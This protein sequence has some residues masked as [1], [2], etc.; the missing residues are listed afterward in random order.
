MFLSF[1]LG[2][3]IAD[4]ILAEIRTLRCIADNDVCHRAGQEQLNY[5]ESDLVFQKLD[6]KLLNLVLILSLTLLSLTDTQG[7]LPGIFHLGIAGYA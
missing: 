2:N 5:K 3:Y 1:C 7:A 4:D 6:S